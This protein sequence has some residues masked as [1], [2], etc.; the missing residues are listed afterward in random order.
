MDYNIENQLNENKQLLLESL[1]S[2]PHAGD[3]RQAILDFV[4]PNRLKMWSM[5][6]RKRF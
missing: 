1:D 2:V 5:N 6:S 4:S 3:E